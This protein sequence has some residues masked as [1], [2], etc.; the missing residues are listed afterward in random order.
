MAATA[1]CMQSCQP[2]SPTIT[3]MPSTQLFAQSLSRSTHGG[4]PL[5]HRA[6]T[7]AS[8]EG[9]QSYKQ[10]PSCAFTIWSNTVSRMLL[11]LCNGSGPMHWLH[12]SFVDSDTNISNSNYETF[13]HSN[14]S[15]SDN[16]GGAEAA[17]L[18]ATLMR[19]VALAGATLSKML[20]ACM[21]A[22]VTPLFWKENL[23]LIVSCTRPNSW[24]EQHGRPSHTFYIVPYIL[25][26]H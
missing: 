2:T 13:E 11:S 5:Q 23:F 15:G 19:T 17:A 22:D 14:G 25:H 24:C 4:P 9:H 8:F 26:C 10:L 3:G 1:Q 20:V 18:E 6:S 7:L 16:D 21:T 12:T